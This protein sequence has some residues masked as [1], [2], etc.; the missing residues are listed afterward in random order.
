M[1][2][3]W[4]NVQPARVPLWKGLGGEMPDSTHHPPTRRKRSRAI[5]CKRSL[6]RIPPQGFLLGP[7]PL[8]PES[9]LGQR[10]RGRAVPGREGIRGGIGVACGEG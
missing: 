4:M 1:E 2:Y 7:Q 5:F 6:P 8:T 3:H 9:E 10:G